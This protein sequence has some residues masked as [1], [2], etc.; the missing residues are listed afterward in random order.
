M[1]HPALL[2][3]AIILTSAFLQAAENTPESIFLEK[4]QIALDAKDTP[5]MLNLVY[6]D[7][8][9]PQMKEMLTKQMSVIVQK[10]VQS[11]ALIDPDPNQI[12]EYT[13]QGKKYKTNLTPI[14]MLKIDYQETI[15]VSSGTLSNPTFTFPVGDHKGSLYITTAV[16]AQSE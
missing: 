3:T 10:Q 16:P 2:A 13:L 9:E 15:P 1:K 6:F 7:G 14:K 11:V 12:F 5:A 8:V 4:V